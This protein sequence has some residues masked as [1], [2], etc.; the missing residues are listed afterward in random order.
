MIRFLPLVVPL[1][2]AAL[3]LGF[4]RESRQSVRGRTKI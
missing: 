2:M 3:S 1:V 4:Y